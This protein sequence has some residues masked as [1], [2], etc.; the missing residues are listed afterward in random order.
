MVKI[1]C[2]DLSENRKHSETNCASPPCLCL[3]GMVG[4]IW[5]APLEGGTVLTSELGYSE[6]LLQSQTLR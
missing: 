2:T 3:E 4:F 1:M 6:D 5:T